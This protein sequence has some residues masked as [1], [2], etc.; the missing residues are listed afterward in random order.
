[1]QP[2][3]DYRPGHPEHPGIT[4]PHTVQQDNLDDP[5]YRTQVLHSHSGIGDLNQALVHLSPLV[6][7][8][9]IRLRGIVDK[10]SGEIRTL[11]VRI[12]NWFLS[13]PTAGLEAFALPGTAA[14]RAGF[15]VR[16]PYGEEEK[17]TAMRTWLDKQT[18]DQTTNLPPPAR[19]VDVGDTVEAGIRLVE[20]A[21]LLAED[22]RYAAL[23]YRWGDTNTLLTTRDS[24]RDRM[25][26]I[27]PN[28]MPKTI[29][30]A[31][32]EGDWTREAAGM[33]NVYMNA[34]CTFS[35][36]AAKHADDGF[37]AESLQRQHVYACGGHPDGGSFQDE[38]TTYNKSADSDQGSTYARH[39]LD[40]SELSSRGWVLQERILSPRLIHFGS[41][42]SLYFESREGVEHVETGLESTYRSFSR[43][44]SALKRLNQKNTTPVPPDVVQ[45][46]YTDWYEIVMQY[47]T[48]SLTKPEDKLVALQGIARKCQE[49][50]GDILTDGVWRN[51]SGFCL[52]WL[53]RE[54]PLERNTSTQ[55]PS[56]SW[57]SAEGKI[58][59]PHGAAVLDIRNVAPE[60]DLAGIETAPTQKSVLWLDN[61]VFINTHL[62]FMQGR[63]G[64]P[65][66]DDMRRFVNL[67]HATR[68]W[69]VYEDDGRY[70]GWASLDR[71]TRQ[72]VDGLTAGISCI[73]IA[74]NQNDQIETGDD[75]DGGRDRGFLVLFIAFS[76]QLGA[77]QRVGMEQILDRRRFQSEAV[78][79]KLV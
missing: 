48:C 24:I 77:W 69:D 64:T 18:G 22:Q 50:T 60:I 11:D 41:G 78:G 30:D 63:V 59:F 71:E 53:S 5:A 66:W 26:D 57:A 51:A 6:P 67:E 8:R 23:S 35:A 65:K 76:S 21:G 3:G 68:Y 34:Q 58:Q 54:E 14:A 49:L 10:D 47:S 2:L 75:G 32:D 44:R 73:K 79:M 12:D 43:L 42:G 37:L 62:H 15:G 56:W 52:L 46:V 16:P 33:G 19:L 70:L 28:S 20:T 9:S 45:H 4:L 13:S 27:P 7:N 72:T 55:I 38:V 36:H 17:W 61:A 31:G 1:M 39:H 25:T 29:R 40:R 74:S